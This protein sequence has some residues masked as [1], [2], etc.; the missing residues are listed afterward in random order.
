MKWLSATAIFAAAIPSITAFGEPNSVDLTKNYN[1]KGYSSDS[2][3]T[4]KNEDSN[5]TT[6]SVLGNVTFSEFT[7]IPKTD[8][9]TTSSSGTPST[10]EIKGGGAFHN[11]QENAPITFI[12]NAGNP[13][14]LTCTEI[15]MTGQGAAIY[16]LG[17]VLIDGLNSVAF[18]NNLSQQSGGAIF[19]SS[20]TITNII[21]SITFSSNS[22]SV[23][24]PVESTTQPSTETSSTT[25]TGTPAA[26]PATTAQ[27]PKTTV[28]PAS[29]S[30]LKT[31]I[32]SS[33]D[34]SPAASAETQSY[35]QETAGN[36]GA[37]Y[38]KGEVI[39]SK[40]NNALFN[41]NSAVV[42]PKAEEAMSST[43]TENTD[44]A[45]LIRGSGGAIFSTGGI[46]FQNSSGTTVFSQNSAQN[47]AGAIYGVSTITFDN[48]NTLKFQSNTSKKDGGAIYSKEDVTFNNLVETRFIKNKSGD[49][50]ATTPPEAASKSLPEEKKVSASSTYPIHIQ[51]TFLS[52]SASSDEKNKADAAEN[53][54][55]AAAAAAKAATKA[56]AEAP[57]K[58]SHGGAIYAK[59]NVSITGIASMLAFIENQATGNGG[60]A[61]IEGT[62]TCTSSHRLQFVKN[63][64]KQSGG[65]L[66][67]KSDVTLKNLTGQT[68]FQENSAEQNGGG[69]CL[70]AEKSLILD[71]LDNFV[72][73]SNTSSQSGGG[74]YIPK[75]FTLTHTSPEPDAE[76]LPVYGAATIT[77]N[78]AS[79][80]GGGIFSKLV[81]FS[82]LSSITID[83]NKATKSGGGLFSGTEVQTTASSQP[84]AKK[85]AASYHIMA[86]ADK[87][88]TRE[89]PEENADCNFDYT[90][91]VTITNNTAGQNGGGL[92]GSIGAFNR[93]DALTIQGNSATQSGGALYFAE[94]LNVTKIVNGTFSGNSAK[95]SGGGIYAKALTLENLPGEISLSDNTLDNASPTT[96]L[97]GGI[98]SETCTLKNISG[99]FLCSKNKINDTST[100]D[101]TQTQSQPQQQQQT[102]LQLQGGGIYAKTSFT[103]QNCS[104]ELIFSENS[105]KT[106]QQSTTKQISG[107]AI[108][109]PTV[110]ISGC[111]QPI[112]FLSNSAAT[113]ATDPSSDTTKKDSI[114]GAIGATTSITLSDNSSIT[115]SKNYAE[116]GGALGCYNSET[117]GN[118]NGKVTISNNNLIRFDGNSALKRGGA[119]YAGTLEI[120]NGNV[121]FQNNTSKY[122]GSAIYCTKSATITAGS[123]ILFLGNTVT[124]AATTAASGSGNTS[125]NNLGAAIY[126]A[127]GSSDVPITLKA[128]SGDIIFKDNQCTANGGTKYC[129]IAGDVQLD[130]KATT[131]RT[132]AF[133]DAVNISTKNG[134]TQN[135]DINKAE[136]GTTYEG[137]VLFSGEYHE[138]KSFIPQ[139]VTLHNGT[140][141][142]G[143]NAELNVISFKQEEGTTVVLGPGAILSNHQKEAGNISLNNVVIDFSGAIPTKENPTASAP[144]LRLVTRTPPPQ[145]Q[146]NDTITLSGTLYLDDPHNNVYNN[147]YLGEDREITLF[148]V[149]GGTINANDL[150]ITGNLGA[151]KGYMGTWSSSP[152]SDASGIKLKWTFDKFLRWEYIPREHNFYINSIW[153][154]QQSLVAVKQGLINNMLSNA[155]FDDAAF[156]NLWISGIGTF[157]RKEQGDSPSYTYHGRGLTVA[158]DAKPRPDFI[159]GASFSKILGHSHSENNLNNYK[160]KSSDHS[161]QASLYTG[162]AFYIPFRY[163]LKRPLLFQGI[164]TYGYM[165]HDTTTTY[166]SINEKNIAN[167]GDRGWLCNA[168][169]SFDL[170]EPSQSS[171]SRFSIYG[172][173]E[174]TEVRQ[175]KFTELDYD[176][177]FFGP[178]AYRNLAFPIGAFIEGALSTY[179]ILLYH[180]L[181][182]AF[183]P[184]FYRNK[185]ISSYKILSTG[186][187][188]NILGVIPTRSA[189]NVEY[190]QQMYLGSYWTIY[191]TY[192]AVASQYTLIQTVNGGLRF[193]F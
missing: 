10:S 110:S 186:Q 135:L 68:L 41:K 184:V 49:F 109:S 117:N 38:S 62:L 190:S 87:K 34:A 157:L 133:Y 144:T 129:S 53:N 57:G 102:P 128:L 47:S 12:T 64:A 30:R 187:I 153:G 122:D 175:E 59:K 48:L 84:V 115:F 164:L 131:G 3:F 56:S 22:A 71:T 162:Q 140:L 180:K 137:T 114:G 100:T 78:S 90:T 85:P 96:M 134:Q 72:L 176:P 69:I 160:H 145:P 105:V 94:S 17:P 91:N 139:K 61:Y 174:Y 178:C 98:Y 173:A 13:G 2:N 179:N 156:N 11:S 45:D 26:T 88:S 130:L 18:N 154:A 92:Y 65:G 107:G 44:N 104:G 183:L 126:G 58:E 23:P 152:T 32:L 143:K 5:G 97:G 36:G 31:L 99:T 9:N 63:K 27:T 101:G 167:W 138:N 168:R 89:A 51:K 74:A 116:M 29:S 60:G 171:T 159:L 108:Y 93:I 182:A 191:G 127:N 161:L 55:V 6:Y 79:E 4:Q 149:S 155:R 40:Y 16:S 82:N 28:P 163:S 151:K 113:S 158:I 132:I 25:T 106:A 67:C 43:G 124:A 33:T 1:G 83:A 14:S 39:L 141:V 8:A 177:R 166:P 188:G 42:D 95:Q 119:I 81:S 147:P 169:F 165:Q 172:E 192:S 76:F 170:K 118:G 150:Q 15:K 19:A 37:V 148:N 73:Q 112:S 142:L 181:S 21:N 7:N 80:N 189:V 111:T 75:A 103:L 46:T 121:T 54:G 123:T 193:V 24:A 77:G 35:T 52:S 125:I 50:Q 86:D 20:L 136:N 120:P 185:P 66:Y 146:V 70:D